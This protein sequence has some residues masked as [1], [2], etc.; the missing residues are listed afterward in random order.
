[1]TIDA[2]QMISDALM[3]EAITEIAAKVAQKPQMKKVDLSAI[4]PKGK[5]ESTADFQMMREAIHQLDQTHPNRPQIL[6]MLRNFPRPEAGIAREMFLINSSNYVFDDE[7][8]TGILLGRD[9]W[10]KEYK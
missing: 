6:T 8:G 7:T 10:E 1:M 2:Q 4:F 5:I 3:N 9:S